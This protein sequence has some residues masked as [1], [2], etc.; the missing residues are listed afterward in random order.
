MELIISYYFESL[1]LLISI[2]LINEDMYSDLP[3]NVNMTWLYATQTF[4]YFMWQWCMYV[5]SIVGN[6]SWLW[7]HFLFIN[8]IYT[9]ACRPAAPL[10]RP[11]QSGAGRTVQWGARGWW[12]AAWTP[13]AECVQSVRGPLGGG[14]APPLS[15]PA[16]PPAADLRWTELRSIL[17]RLLEIDGNRNGWV[18]WFVGRQ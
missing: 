17:V 9:T 12:S 15:E 2:H 10:N 6:I 7:E 16:E 8:V 4:T 13:P 5:P 3:S 18:T 11:G 1:L 14:A